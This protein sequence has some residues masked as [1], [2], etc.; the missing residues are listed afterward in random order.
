MMK[1]LGIV[2]SA[3]LALVILA[4]GTLYVVSG[5]RMRR[6]YDVGAERVTVPTDPEAIRRGGHIAMI[7]GCTDCHGADLGGKQFID[8]AM[9]GTFYT[10][11][12]TAG[13]GGIGK[14]FA[15]ADWEH[16]LRHGITPDGRGLLIMPSLEF[17]M[18]GDE[19]LGALIAY[20][21][22]LPPVDHEWPLS[23][24]G[25]LGRML[26]VFDLAPMIPAE[27]IDHTAA[28]AKAPAPGVTPEY[29]AYL[30]VSCKGCH[31]EDFAGGKIPGMHGLI[32]ANL[33]MD[34]ATGLGRWGEADFLEA[35][36]TGR[37][38]DGSQLNPIMPLLITGN[39]TDTEVG[40]I[41]QFLRTLPVQ[42]ARTD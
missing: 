17:R 13:T 32:A 18:L 37:R 9:L 7:R 38:P 6:H 36:H 33:T 22:S 27:S 30:A 11:N 23:R 16:A 21:Q 14:T 42:T 8:D 15:L 31:Q 29:G 3:A 5:H 26:L 4:V 10:P 2:V 35:M 12:L 20:L 19:D 1:L 24:V 28:H 34:E 39:M 41:W 25:P 40:A